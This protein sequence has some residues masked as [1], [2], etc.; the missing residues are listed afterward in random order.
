MTRTSVWPPTTHDPSAV[1]HAYADLLRWPLHVGGQ[2]VTAEQ[3]ECLLAAGPETALETTGSLFDTVTVAYALGLETLVRLD[4]M[5]QAP[6][7][8]CFTDGRSTV[9]F[10]LTPG[11]GEGL[12]GLGA[13]RVGAGGPVVLP[14]SAGLRWDTPPWD[15][16]VPQQL[17][18]PT[19]GELAPALRAAL[20]LYGQS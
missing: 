20:R 7:V 12:A 4:R 18:L 14:P 1:L 16:T 11:A 10:L 8:P 5:P 3:A 13:V 17:E 2:P 6:P 9:T 15:C 19:A